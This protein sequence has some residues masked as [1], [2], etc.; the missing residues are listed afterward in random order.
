MVGSELIGD[1][2][3]SLSFLM[4]LA[5]SRSHRLRVNQRDR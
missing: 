1:E 2:K 3:R 5:L 4:L